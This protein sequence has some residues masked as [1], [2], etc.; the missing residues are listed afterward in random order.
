MTSTLTDSD[1]QCID[2]PSLISPPSVH[3]CKECSIPSI[4]SILGTTYTIPRPTSAAKGDDSLLW[5]EVE[6]SIVRI[7]IRLFIEPSTY[8]EEVKD[9]GHLQQLAMRSVGGGEYFSLQWLADIKRFWLNLPKPIRA[10]L[11]QRTRNL[12]PSL[13]RDE[14]VLVGEGPEES[15][16]ERKLRFTRER[17]Q[18][19]RINR[20]AK[21][22]EKPKEPTSSTR[23]VEEPPVKR[24][25]EEEPE[26][27]KQVMVVR[28]ELIKVQTQ[29]EKLKGEL[30][31]RAKELATLWESGERSSDEEVIAFNKLCEVREEVQKCSTQHTELVGKMRTASSAL[32][33]LWE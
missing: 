24:R 9:L 8:H 25:K 15:A 26:L 13:S 4:Q 18:R 2:V 5:S 20:K 23:V 17:Q 22:Q 32:A 28:E 1:E 16:R 7:I 29:Q 14:L 19:Y 21:T 3:H 10:T 31:E 11:I 33:S 12:L 30:P 27:F 6:L